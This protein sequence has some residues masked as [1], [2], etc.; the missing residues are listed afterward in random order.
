MNVKSVIIAEAKC[1][2]TLIRI[3]T[4]DLIGFKWT[5]LKSLCLCGI[6]TFMLQTLLD[7][8]RWPTRRNNV[9]YELLLFSY[10]SGVFTTGY[11]ISEVILDML[12][13]R[14]RYFQGMITLDS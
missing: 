6:G 10:V 9:L 8:D 4:R 13:L 12:L 1:S 3:F 11:L 7:R 2:W 5:P 14:R